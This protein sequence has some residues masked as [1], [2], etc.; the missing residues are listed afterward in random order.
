MASAPHKPFEPTAPRLLELR[1]IF[2]CMP[3]KVVLPKCWSEGAR[4]T[5]YIR[6]LFFTV[7][8]VASIP[9]LAQQAAGPPFGAPRV[10]VGPPGVE[11]PLVRQDQSDCTN[12]NVTAKDLSRIGGTVWVNRN[13]SGNTD[14]TVAI[15]GTPNTTYHFFL[16]CV[17]ILGDIK[18]YD[19]GEGKATFSFPTNSV[20][21]IYAFDM[22]PEGAPPGP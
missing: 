21:N 10:P 1:E 11:I 12:S 8:A 22:Y 20:G 15:S 3:V 17:R 13:S 14:V 16:K 6:A 4:V 9:C 7:I 2:G 18:T 19:E 5:S